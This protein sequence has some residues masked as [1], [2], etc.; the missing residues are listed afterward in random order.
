MAAASYPGEY[1][2]ELSDSA[3]AMALSHQHQHHQSQQQ[4]QNTFGNQQHMEPNGGYYPQADTVLDT[5]PVMP[6]G[7][8][9]PHFAN[10]QPH[11]MNELYMDLNTESPLMGASDPMIGAVM[12]GGPPSSEGSATTAPAT[13]AT[14]APSQLSPDVQWDTQGFSPETDQAQANVNQQR[15]SNHMDLS[16]AVLSYWVFY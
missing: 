7:G 4:Q 12:G 3:A 5:P 10:H 15:H 1:L 14:V 16:W 9:R 8:Q 11:Y 6:Y 13:H 2:T